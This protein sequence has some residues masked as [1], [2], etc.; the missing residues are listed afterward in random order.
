MTECFRLSNFTKASEWG[1]VSTFDFFPCD[2]HV[3]HI[4]WTKIY[5]F[6]SSRQSFSLFWLVM[7]SPGLFFWLVNLHTGAELSFD[8]VS[9]NLCFMIYHC[10]FCQNGFSIFI[11]SIK[12]CILLLYCKINISGK[13]E[14]LK[15]WVFQFLIR[16][17]DSQKEP[18]QEN[19]KSFSLR[20]NKYIYKWFVHYYRI[21]IFPVEQNKH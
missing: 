19:Y 16:D 17:R 2:C 20:Q 7:P 3:T 15:V 12:N 14:S 18:D 11:V 9:L 4:S 1:T 5:T 13:M 8:H 21:N 6:A 10:C